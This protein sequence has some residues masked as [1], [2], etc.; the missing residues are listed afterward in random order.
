M[1]QFKKLIKIWKIK[2]SSI[3]PILLTTKTQQ[4]RCW[5]K[6][7]NNRFFLF[8]VKICRQKS[9]HWDIHKKIKQTTTQ[10]V[11]YIIKINLLSVNQDWTTM[12]HKTKH[13]H[14]EPRY[15]Q[16][17][18]K[19]LFLFPWRQSLRS[20]YQIFLFYFRIVSQLLLSWFNSDGPWKE[21]IKNWNILQI[22]NGIWWISLPRET[23]YLTIGGAKETRQK[24]EDF[25]IY[26]I[27]VDAGVGYD[28]ETIPKACG[29]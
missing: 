3:I 11:K 10:T 7:R 15:L 20:P 19:K 1:T 24:R 21:Q 25:R 27:L 8:F 14:A 16:K 5:W 23:D 18:W 12:Q 9:F 13:F 22:G 29:R 26:H 17:Q 28:S 4:T 6:N 2:R